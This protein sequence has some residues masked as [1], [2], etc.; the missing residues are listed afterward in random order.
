MRQ[1]PLLFS[2]SS[3]QGQNLKM[4]S[5][6][7]LGSPGSPVWHSMLDSAE[8][9]LREEG[10]GALTSRRVAERLGVKQR[11]VYYY[12]R[13]MEDLIAEAFRRLATRELDRLRQATSGAL[14]LREVWDVCI[15][16]HDAR[17]VAEFTALA[18]RSDALRK[19]VVHFIEE[20]RTMHVAAL[21]K[22]LKAGEV[23]GGLPAVV[24][25][26]FATSAALTLHRE[27]GIGVRMGHDQILRVISGFI[28]QWEGLP[29]VRKLARVT[30]RSQGLVANRGPA[31][32]KKRPLRASRA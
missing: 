7:R 1:F 24:L 14:P 29:A 13:T 27:A 11:L 22:A 32:R 17:M 3:L 30:G 25:A 6:R 15:H 31:S 21:N 12:F 28:E 10:Y 20:S 9:I 26:I 8:D 23:E 5:N 16:T 2:I 19:E 4:T 18:N